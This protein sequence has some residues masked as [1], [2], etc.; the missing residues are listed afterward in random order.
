MGI[1]GLSHFLKD[2]CSGCTKEINIKSLSGQKIA[3]DASMCLYQF[4]IAVRQQDS[5]MQLNNAEGETT[6]H[7]MGFFYRTLRMCDNGIKP[8][9]VFDGKP[10]VLK[11]GELDKRRA[12]R[13]EAEEEI[14]N[15]H[16]KLKEAGEVEEEEDLAAEEAKALEK[17]QMERL[18]L[19]QRRTV[20][21]TQ[22]QNDEAQH[23]LS[24]MGIPYVVAPCEA[25]A[26]CVELCKGGKV[27]A[28]ASEDMDTLCYNVPVL[29]RKLTLSEQR[30]EPI[31]E[32]RTEKILEGLE[33]TLDEFIDLCIMMGCDY[34]PTIQ[35]CG[36]ANSFK[37]ITE[38]RSIEAILKAFENGEIVKKNWKI[39]SEWLYKES[40]ELFVNPEVIKAEDVDLKWL[41]PKEEELIDFM[42]NKNGFSEERIKSGIERLKKNLKQGTQ[43]RLDGFFKVKPSEQ[44]NTKS[45]KKTGKVT[46]PQ[47]K[48]K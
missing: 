28:V 39:P 35:G 20:K 4:L 2:N 43:K 40:K 13:D 38:Y 5:G 34:C 25:E 23:L 44:S 45:N 12:K 11:S 21:V 37:L 48:R 7:L 18:M 32:V 41:P 31:L 30:K 42:V 36:P 24:L 22:K 15:L 9:Y 47:R 17:E 1:K 27:Y 19:L 3:I 8:M 6:S 46:K 26:Q 16:K 33:L 14:K 29:L 10:P